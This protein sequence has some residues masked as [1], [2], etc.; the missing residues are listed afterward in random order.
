MRRP[1]FKQGTYTPQNK[2]KYIREDF[3]NLQ[4]I[5]GTESILVFRQESK[6]AEMG[7]R[8]LSHPLC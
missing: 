3:A 7:L 4:V 8:E 2:E 6:S 1:A 5:L